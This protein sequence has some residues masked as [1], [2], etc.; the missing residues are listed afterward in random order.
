M[1][2]R[3]KL[4]ALLGAGVLAFGIYGLAFAADAAS[5]QGVVPTAHSGNITNSGNFAQDVCS[6]DDAVD[7]A[8]NNDTADVSSDA[9]TVNGVTVHLTVNNTTKAVSFTADGGLVTAAFIKGGD[10]YNEY[11]YS[12]DLG[13][14]VDSDSNLFPPDNNGGGKGFSHAVFCTGQAEGSTPPSEGPSTPPSEVPSEAPSFAG[15]VADITD[16][17]S[18]PNTATIGTSNGG[19]TDSSWLFIAAIGVLLGSVVVMTPARAKN[20]R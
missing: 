6:A 19:P 15:S 7:M 5:T 8:G 2:Q 1:K 17:P 12:G 4:A 14:G 18:E 13:H 3:T 20:R 16:A 10:G 11:D 9:T